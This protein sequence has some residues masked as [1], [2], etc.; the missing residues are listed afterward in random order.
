MRVDESKHGT[1][2]ELDG[3]H[4]AFCVDRELGKVRATRL[5]DELEIDKAHIVGYSMGGGIALRLAADHPDRVRSVVLGGAGW[6]PPG[7]PLPA[8]VASESVVTVG[9]CMQENKSERH[10]KGCPPNNALVVK[11]IIGDRAEVKR[12][13]AGESL[14][15]TDA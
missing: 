11:A 5:L 8:E 12:M 6:A 3:V 2:V 9:L 13:Y 4:F 15:K 14:D 7:A 10:V 1:V